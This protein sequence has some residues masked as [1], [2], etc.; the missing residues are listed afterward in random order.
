MQARLFLYGFFCVVYLLHHTPNK[1]S[2][3]L[4][5]YR[6]FLWLFQRWR[7][8]VCAFLFRICSIFLGFL[9]SV[10]FLPLAGCFDQWSKDTFVLCCL[11]QT[12]CGP[13]LSGCPCSAPLFSHLE[14]NDT[15][16]IFAV[17]LGL[18]VMQRR[19][20]LIFL[21]WFILVANVIFPVWGIGEREIMHTVTHCY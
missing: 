2:V 6:L 11:E 21:R 5:G 8:W 15:T 3:C 14:L 4:R 19:L 20:S 1:M 7:I 18:D 17:W 9:S 13:N 10:E 16:R 12:W